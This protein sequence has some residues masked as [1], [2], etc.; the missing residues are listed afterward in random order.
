MKKKNPDSNIENPNTKEIN[1]K[2]DAEAEKKAL[3]SL[4]KLFAGKTSGKFTMN[5]EKTIG[6]MEESYRRKGP[7][8]EAF[9][10]SRM[11]AG[12][13]PHARLKGTSQDFYMTGN[14][15]SGQFITEAPPG[16]SAEERVE[17]L[18]LPPSN[19]GQDLY[20]VQLNEPHVVIESNVAPQDE[21][22]KK[23]GYR[24]V[25]G[26]KQIFVP[27]KYG[28]TEPHITVKEQV[29]GERPHVSQ[30]KKNEQAPA[31]G[32]EPKDTQKADDTQGEPK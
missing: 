31:D 29:D 15:A 6:I 2:P 4:P 25:E 32:A 11:D 30:M 26:M 7:E 10:K 23:S 28:D 24:P 21:F 22:A 13:E 19:D 17:N 5:T 16:E 12:K 1:D 3:D 27:P 9:F 20:K 14:E 8:A 18:Q